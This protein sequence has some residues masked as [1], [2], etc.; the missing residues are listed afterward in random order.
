MRKAYNWAMSKVGSGMQD[1]RE[2]GS[3][4]G[5]SSKGQ[6][7]GGPG[8]IAGR[9]GDMQVTVDG[10]VLDPGPSQEIHNHSP[11]GFAWGYGGL[12]PAQLALAILLKF[13]NRKTAIRL[14]QT[15]KADVVCRLPQ[16][17]SFSM[18][19]ERVRFWLREWA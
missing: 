13:S 8:V 5:G 10:E 7:I 9:W 6:P 3:S 2:F 17:D 16:A 12:G 19:T 15:F 18:T 11:G 1:R 14:Y 4:G